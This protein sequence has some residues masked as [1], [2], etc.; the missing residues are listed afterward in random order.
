MDPVLPS[1]ADCPWSAASTEA[2]VFRVGGCFPR[3]PALPAPPSSLSLAQARLEGGVFGEKAVTG[4]G[5]PCPFP[6]ACIR[7][8]VT[9]LF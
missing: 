1:W 7:D 8:Q 2:R 6:V 3:G 9:G 5:R 4:R